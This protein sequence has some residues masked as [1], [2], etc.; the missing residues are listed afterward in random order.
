MTTKREYHNCKH[1][2]YLPCPE[3]NNEFMM[4]TKVSTPPGPTLTEYDI[5]Q[6]NK[7]M[8]KMQKI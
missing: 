3:K 2:L 4:K 5:E 6:I 7:T 1:W 8:P